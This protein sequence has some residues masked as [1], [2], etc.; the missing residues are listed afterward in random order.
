MNPHKY[1]FD[2]HKLHYRKL[3]NDLRKRVLRALTYILSSIFVAVAF[4][5][6]FSLIFD[7]PRE[8]EER[9][10]FEALS[11][12][13]AILSEK[14]GNVD[15]V[16]KELKSIDENIYRTIFEA[17]PLGG[18][19]SAGSRPADY[20]Y[21]LE[22]SNRDIIENTN[23]EVNH[24]MQVINTQSAEYLNLMTNAGRR[25]EMLSNIPAIQPVH[26]EDLTRLASG[27]G[28][29]MHPFY[30]IEKFHEGIDFTAPTGTEVYAAGDGTVAD[31][32]R[33]G[34]GY[35]N[36]VIIDHGFGYKTS[37]SHLDK[38]NVRAGQRIKRKD[39]IGLVGSTG[40]SVAPHLHYEV[41]LHDKPVNP[42]N[43][44][45]LDLTPEEY[46]RMIELSVKSGQS[47]D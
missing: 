8:R 46:D 22:K 14:Y 37:Y 33:S 17:E 38:I 21:L 24:K 35:G 36:I 43:Y 12:D 9:Q 40:L 31:I 5:G 7:T 41:L 16:L 29:R 3:E 23:I 15:T 10:E 6:L 4:L 19:T 25:N 13:Y 42:V 34:R 32:D 20:T 47:F 2:P 30:K 11:Q 45:F 39:V 44:F 27:F 28:Y 26:N 18:L 1:I